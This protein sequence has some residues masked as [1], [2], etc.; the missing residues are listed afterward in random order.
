VSS[1]FNEPPK[2]EESVVKKKLQSRRV[3]ALVVAAGVVVT[4]AGV[5]L[6][7]P[8]VGFVA[9]TLAR[10]KVVELPGDEGMQSFTIDMSKPMELF[11]QTITLQPGG[12]VGWHSHPGPQFVIVKSGTATDYALEASCA[13][14]VI[15]AGEAFI[16]HHPG[17]VHTVT[18]EGSVPVEFIVTSLGPVGAAFRTDIPAPWQNPAY[19]CASGSRANQ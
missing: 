12:T 4:A 19:G 13:P 18:N 14:H 6:A 1:F 17:A 2:K 15:K 10:G 11:T 3:L 8:P 5:A 9:S 7:T 16:Y